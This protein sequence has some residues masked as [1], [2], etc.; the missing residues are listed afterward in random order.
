MPPIVV[1]TGESRLFQLP[2]LRLVG[3]GNAWVAVFFVLLGFVN[4]LKAVQ[5]ARAGAVGDA[6]NSLASSTFRR[7]GRLVFPATAVTAIA[8]FICQLGG[9]QL[10]RQTDAWWVRETS[11]Q[12]SDSWFGAI[13]DLVVAVVMTWTEGD[14]PYDQPQWA[15]L[16][17]FKASLYVF[18][19]LLA[20]VNTSS[21]F[22]LA[23][24]GFLYIYSWYVGDGMFAL[25]KLPSGGGF[26]AKP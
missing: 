19:T 10:A 16:H 13:Q 9:N 25:V 3:Q 6:L 11:A 20:L 2:Y 4:S 23:A 24:E 26:P 14:N 17:L 22:R 21:R 1:E 15:L 7:T 5:L 8:W 12:P 18:L